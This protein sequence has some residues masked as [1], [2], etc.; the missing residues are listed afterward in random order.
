VLQC[1]LD[2]CKGEEERRRRENFRPSS[3]ES[4]AQAEEDSEGIIINEGT[5]VKHRRND[6]VLISPL[7]SDVSL[8]RS[9]GA[10]SEWKLR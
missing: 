6:L 3:S 9:G 4:D 8:E 5:V 1:K 7:H 2:T 10:W